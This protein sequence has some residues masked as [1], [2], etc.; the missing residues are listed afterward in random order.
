MTMFNIK[1]QYDDMDS[2]P[3]EKRQEPAE[4]LVSGCSPLRKKTDPTSFYR[5]DPS[6]FVD[7]I[8]GIGTQLHKSALMRTKLDFPPPSAGT[9]KITL[10]FSG[11]EY[12]PSEYHQPENNPSLTTRVPK[13]SSVLPPENT[14]SSLKDAVKLLR[15]FSE[16]VSAE[17]DRNAEEDMIREDVQM[18]VKETAKDPEQDVLREA[19]DESCVEEKPFTA[20]IFSPPEFSFETS[21]SEEVLPEEPETG[22]SEAV[23]E[24]ISDA[25]EPV[26]EKPRIEKWADPRKKQVYPLPEMVKQLKYN[27]PEEFERLA[28]SLDRM[29]QDGHTR[30]AFCG[31]EPLTGCSTMLLCAAHGLTRLGRKVTVIDAHFLSPALAEILGI[32]PPPNWGDLIEEKTLPEEISCSADNFCVIPLRRNTHYTWRNI[33]PAQLQQKTQEMVSAFMEKSDMILI[34]CG[35]AASANTEMALAALELFLPDGILWVSRSTAMQENISAVR[36]ELRGQGITELGLVVNF[37]R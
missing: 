1:T 7:A 17:N 33:D 5:N 35:H 13:R 27:A 16:L 14:D 8:C 30:I 25:E 32:F 22:E 12:R 15:T 3:Q 10:G 18:V 9:V 24:E 21:H 28:C 23:S 6:S 11:S 31:T 34:D 2:C 19:P 26:V 4:S 20:E 29:Y 36:Q 37:F